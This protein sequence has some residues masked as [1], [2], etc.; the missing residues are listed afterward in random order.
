MKQ[1]NNLQKP[2]SSKELEELSDVFLDTD[3]S[4][5]YLHGYFCAIISA[6]TFLMPSM[7][8][9][10]LYNKIEFKSEAQAGKIITLILRFYNE[11]SNQLQNNQ[12]KP[13][14]Y[15]HENSRLEELEIAEDWSAGYLDGVDIDPMWSMLEE[16][17]KEMG[18]MLLPF[19]WTAGYGSFKEDD[20]V[21]VNDL[22]GK[23]YK[24][25]MFSKLEETT[26]FFYEVWNHA[27]RE[28]SSNFT[29]AKEQGRNEMCACGS[30]KKYKKCCLNVEKVVH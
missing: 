2:L 30:G 9:Q 17:D 18:L 16:T 11:V 22:K 24:K 28:Y 26:R 21:L 4:I 29:P 8:Q 1:N 20:G 27:R 14:L 6:P 15:K 3:L 12:F 25:L 7:W 13:F 10:P 5:S 19:I 23:E